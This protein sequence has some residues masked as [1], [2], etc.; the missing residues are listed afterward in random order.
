LKH[1]KTK[2]FPKNIPVNV[3][4]SYKNE[5]KGWGDFLGTGNI[6][7]KPDNYRTYSEAKKYA[8][9]LKLKT[10]K[11]WLKFTKSKEFPKDIYVRPDLKV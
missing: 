9:K 2:D 11:D 5:W 10:F 6:A 8:R 4:Q 3:Y 7:P 1:S